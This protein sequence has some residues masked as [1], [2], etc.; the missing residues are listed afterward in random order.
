MSL[1]LGSCARVTVVVVCV[2]VTAL[3]AHL[4]VE[5]K[6]PLGFLWCFQ[7]MHCVAFVKN[8]LFKS[9]GDTC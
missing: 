3:A 8:A 9:S 5:N 4:H 6:V 2:S 1:T 7:D